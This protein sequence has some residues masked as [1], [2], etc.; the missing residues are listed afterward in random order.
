M[1]YKKILQSKEV[2]HVLMVL[3]GLAVILF[4]FLLGEVVGFRKA[5]FSY[6]LGER[7]Y[8]NFAGPRNGLPGDLRAQDFLSGH[9]ATG[10]I[11][12]ISSSSLIIQDRDGSEKT[13][14]FDKDTTLRRFRD[15]ISQPDLK[16]GDIVTAFGSPNDKG[17]ITAKLIRVMPFTAGVSTD[18]KASSSTST[19]H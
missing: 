17:E 7:Y 13:I 14:L 11:L 18:I 6:G 19:T 10:S 8:Q 4:I 3:G 16:I 5:R 2:K 15:S 12:S 1:E 9:G